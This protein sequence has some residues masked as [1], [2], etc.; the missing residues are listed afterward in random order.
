MK[1]DVIIGTR[2][3][4]IKVAVFLKEIE[5]RNKTLFK[6]DVRLIHTGQ[7]YDDNLSKEI[8]N[9]LEIREPSFSVRKHFF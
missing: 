7:H 3:N 1:I 2:P 5:K 6:Y 4:F 9:D 8:L